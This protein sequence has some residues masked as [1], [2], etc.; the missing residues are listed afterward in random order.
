MDNATVKRTASSAVRE[1]LE[2]EILTGQLAPGDRLDESQIGTRFGVS[3]TP[4]R[5]A[6]TQLAAVDLVEIRPHRGAF[7]KVV[8]MPEMLA[9][10]EVMTELEGFCARL[11]A[12]RCT[13]A[14]LAGLEDV[15]AA[16]ERSVA[17]GDVDDYYYHNEEFHRLLYRASGN[18]FLARTAEGLHVR[19]R[20][21]RRLQL[22]V[23]GR[24]QRSLEE[25][26]RVL[27]AIRRGEASEAEAVM[28]RHVAVQGD[29]F[30][31]FLAIFGDSDGAWER[32]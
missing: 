11:A 28:K 25:H 16:C 24:L 12:R 29:N 26:R 17:A 19:L 10:F 18:A 21:F 3:R 27:E 7:V 14:Q 9:M 1:A 8:A 31:D 32:T 22:R 30:G 13:E 23:A 20:P 5:E 2:H 4:V 15:H 6:L